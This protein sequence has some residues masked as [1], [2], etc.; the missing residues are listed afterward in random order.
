MISRDCYCEQIEV[1]LK[2]TFWHGGLCP[3]L[4]SFVLF[5]LKMCLL[6]LVYFLLELRSYSTYFLDG[7][8]GSQ[9]VLSASKWV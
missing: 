9:V 6:E 8:E 3:L 2:M 4:E 7:I 1:V 5:Y